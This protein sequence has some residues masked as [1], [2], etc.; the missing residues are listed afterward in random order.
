MR[1]NILQ[2]LLIMNRQ[3]IIYRKLQKKLVKQKKYDAAFKHL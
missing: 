2:K 3:V 1:R